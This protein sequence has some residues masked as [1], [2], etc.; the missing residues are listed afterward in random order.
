MLLPKVTRMRTKISTVLLTHHKHDWKKSVRA[1]SC[2][3]LQKAFVFGGEITPLKIKKRTY[4]L[5]LILDVG[6]F[7]EL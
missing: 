2:I 5:E 1:S 6:H 3:R 7:G 4:L